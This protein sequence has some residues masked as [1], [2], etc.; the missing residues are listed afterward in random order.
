MKCE[1]CNENDATV[2]LKQMIN[3]ETKE[4]FVCEGCAAKQSMSAAS[5][6]NLVDFL[7]GVGMSTANE[8]GSNKACPSC[9]IQVCELR[10]NMRLGCPDCYKAFP[11]ELMPMLEEM[12][13]DTR[14]TGKVPDAQRTVSRV[15][16]LKRALSRAVAGEEFEQAAELRDRISAINDGRGESDSDSDDRQQELLL[17]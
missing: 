9:G 4:L 14:H 7:F 5:P 1:T 13:E 16:K 6:L 17:G 8:I 11:D 15:H 3:G 12:H 2:H 10:K